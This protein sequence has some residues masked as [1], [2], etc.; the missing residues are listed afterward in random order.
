MFQEYFGI[1]GR[2]IVPDLGTGLID[3]AKTLEPE[4]S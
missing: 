3:I 1:V 4:V 2:G